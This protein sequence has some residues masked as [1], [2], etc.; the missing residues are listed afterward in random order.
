MRR[1][2]ITTPSH[3]PLTKFLSVALCF[4]LIGLEAAPVFARSNDD[5]QF[6]NNNY[7]NNYGSQGGYSAQSLD[8]QMQRMSARIQ[9]FTAPPVHFNSYSQLSLPKLNLSYQPP[10]RFQYVPQA[11]V[12]ERTNQPVVKL[13]TFTPAA[14][15]TFLQNVGQVFK[16]IGAAI[17]TA[18]KKIGDGIVSLSHKIFGSNQKQEVPVTPQAQDLMGS[19]KNL[20]EIAPGLLQTQN[21]KTQALGQAWEPGSTFKGDGK[22]LRLVEGTAYGPNL[23]GITRADG[24][25]LPIKYAEVAGKVSPV[26]LDF[27][28]LTKETTLKIQ[29]PV[30]IEGFGMIMGGDMVFKGTT[31]TPEGPLGKFQFQGA[32]VQLDSAMSD[33]LDMSGPASLARAT[34]MVKA[35]VM[36][37]NSAVIEKGDKQVFVSRTHAPIEV[38]GLEKGVNALDATS[39][40]NFS[41]ISNVER[42]LSARSNAVS[43]FFKTVSQ[44]TGLEATLN[45][46][47]KD[48]FKNLSK[49]A[50][51]IRQ[52]SLNLSQSIENVSYDTIKEPL[53]NLEQRQDVLTQKT[54]GLE[55]QAESFREVQ[56]GMRGVTNE[57]VSMLPNIDAD[58]LKT[59]APVPDQEL[60]RRAATYFPEA[61]AA[62]CQQ[63]EKTLEGIKSLVTVGAMA[64]E[65]GA[66]LGAQ[67]MAMRD[68]ILSAVPNDALYDQ[69]RAV[70][71]PLQKTYDTS[72]NLVNRGAD[73]AFFG[74]MGKVAESHPTMGLVVGT[75]GLRAAQTADVANK[76]MGTAGLVYFGVTATITTASAL[77]T[78]YVAQNVLEYVGVDK[79]ASTA[80]A[81]VASILVA[82]KVGS[83]E[84]VQAAERW[85]PK[86]ILSKAQSAWGAVKGVF[87]GANDLVL[88]ERGHLAIGKERYSYDSRIDRFRNDNSGRFTA[89]RDLPYPG[90][91]GFAHS[92]RVEIKPGKIVDRYGPPVGRFASEVGATVSERGLP[93]GTEGMAYHKYEVV[94]PMQVEAGPAAPVKEFGAKGR[95]NQYRFDKPISRLLEEGYLR[96]IR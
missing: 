56:R 74:W 45:F 63:T 7:G 71:D 60:A 34:F 92:V 4:A 91:G 2:F 18:F 95:A 88:N 85:I 36:E 66:K 69:K 31:P 8:L 22:A 39:S 1:F 61:K 83:S 11:K 49:E 77:G 6:N 26:G 78:A 13:D 15:P 3:F 73:A 57:L 20:K 54:Q 84:Q 80:Y 55:T 37:L 70:A 67:M 65:Q 90:D 76:A 89:Q 75:V 33:S 79:D 27:T 62:V 30:N 35:A 53:Q 51:D 28:L 12:A 47:F 64:P 93:P 82:A 52:A 19:F 17:T 38:S 29:A 81:T 59:E 43:Q 96:E 94:R 86:A 5:Y 24:A 87:G 44:Q 42:D 14:K 21:G 58:R 41:K 23:G 46:E 32:K 9:S 40:A 72:K 10:I 68:K 25:N 16:G 48:D 50:G